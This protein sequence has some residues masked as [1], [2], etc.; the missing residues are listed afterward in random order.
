MI[1][2]L[3]TAHKAA[4]DFQ[5]K[6]HVEKESKEGRRLVFR[7]PRR[8][9][10]GECGVM[11]IDPV[12]RGGRVTGCCSSNSWGKKPIGGNTSRENLDLL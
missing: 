6:F 5:V 10:G 4:K 2:G 9:W 1:E 12:S 3:R 11:E 8:G 7:L